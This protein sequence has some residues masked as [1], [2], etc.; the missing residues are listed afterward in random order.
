MLGRLAQSPLVFVPIVALLAAAIVPH[1]GPD[2]PAATYIGSRNQVHVRIP[3]IDAD[4]RID[5]RL[6]EAV[7][8]RA[9]VLTGFSQFSPQDGVPADDSTQVLVWYSST[10]VHFGI[11]AFERHGAPVATLADRDRIDAD[12]Q[13]QLLLSTFND[14][15]QALVFGVNPLGVQMDGTILETNRQQSGSFMSQ[16][17]ARQ[18]ADLSQ[19]FVFQSKGR[20]TEYGYEVEIRI[21][22]KSLRYQPTET[23]SWGLNIVRVVQHS[24][25]EDSWA[26]ARRAAA[27]FLG[28]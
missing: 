15:R 9:A 28:Q 1:A 26:P 13:V 4:A 23:Q 27:S 22:F 11:R 18:Q 8:R 2:E 3:R 6:D 25:F 20:V 12:D 14:G 21:P 19:D 7:W 5:G 24:G 10:A 17:T 16:A